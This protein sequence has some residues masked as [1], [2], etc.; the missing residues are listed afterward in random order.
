MG[1]YAIAV[2]RQIPLGSPLCIRLQPRPEIDFPHQFPV[3]IH[4]I[5]IMPFVQ[6]VKL[7]DGLLVAD[8]K[9]TTET[10][11]YALSDVGDIRPVEFIPATR[12]GEKLAVEFA[13]AELS[14]IFEARWL[15]TE[16]MRD[17]KVDPCK[18]LCVP[19]ILCDGICHKFSL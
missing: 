1:D 7:Q 18:V 13:I 11:V 12:N 3:S 6:F 5:V 19:R 15:V 4:K 16:D 17:I 8:E 2:I 10:P 9:P 14:Q